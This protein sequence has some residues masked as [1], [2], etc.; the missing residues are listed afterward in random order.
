[1]GRSPPDAW[2]KASR[3]RKPC[4]SPRRDSQ[5]VCFLAGPPMRRGG[6][7]HRGDHQ[8]GQHL[9]GGDAPVAPQGRGVRT[10]RSDS[11]PP[12]SRFSISAW[13]RRRRRRGTITAVGRHVVGT[14]GVHA[15][16]KKTGK[17]GRERVD[18][19]CDL[20]I[21]RSSCTALAKGT[22]GCR[23][24]ANNTDRGAPRHDGP[25]DR[26]G[27]RRFGTNPG[28]FPKKASKRLG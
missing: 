5:T 19:R 4:G 2:A 21:W 11:R 12:A 24:K 8:A 17:K 6:L 13:H 18:E 22:G 20:Y 14:A 27:S 3:R 26:A 23:S 1:L 15:A 9:A 7:I 10:P 25:L 16:S 28:N